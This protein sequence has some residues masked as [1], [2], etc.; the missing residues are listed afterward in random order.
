MAMP[1]IRFTKGAETF[2]FSKGRSFPVDDPVQVAVSTEYSEGGQLYAYDKGIVEQFYNLRFDR[3]P[4]ADFDNFENWL[5]NV[6]VGPKFTFIYT[7][8]EGVDHT[9]RLLNTKNPLTE[10]AHQLYSGTIRLREEI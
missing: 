5:K 7:D 9:V 2:T 1:N 6:V 4:Q 3:L 10:V 8:E